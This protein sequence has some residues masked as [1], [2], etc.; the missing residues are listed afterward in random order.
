METIIIIILLIIAWVSITVHR[1]N[2]KVRKDQENKDRI[3]GIPPQKE[4]I[5]HLKQKGFDFMNI[6]EMLESD[7]FNSKEA[8]KFHLT[9]HYFE[10]IVNEK[11]KKLDNNFFSDN[12]PYSEGFAIKSF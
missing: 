12:Y 3:K 10:D 2:E 1:D 11:L 4:M 8:G 7:S 6:L 5:R 9:R